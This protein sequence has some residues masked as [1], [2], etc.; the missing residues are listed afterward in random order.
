MELYNELKK[1]GNYLISIRQAE[2]FFFMDLKFPKSWLIQQ[3]LFEEKKVVPFGLK[4]NDAESGI[5]F[6][7][8]DN[9]AEFGKV[10][11]TILNLIKRNIEI[12]KKNELLN[13]SIEKLKLLFNK[14]NLDDLNNLEF[15]LS[16]KSLEY[17]NDES[18]KVN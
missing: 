8:E 11:K 15:S 10:M 18:A 9:P 2:G 7:I 6:V 1:I 13:V 4:N 14:S 5:S 16:K 3:K 12:E 17:E